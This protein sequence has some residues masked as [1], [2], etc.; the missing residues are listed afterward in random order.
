MITEQEEEQLRRLEEKEQ[1]FY[2]GAMFLGA[3]RTERY[4][5]GQ[6]LKS[7]PPVASDVADIV[8]GVFEDLNE[9]AT[10]R[11]TA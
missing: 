10:R 7:M 11:D 5:F 8:V 6:R 4:L 1:D 9:R 3:M 2:A